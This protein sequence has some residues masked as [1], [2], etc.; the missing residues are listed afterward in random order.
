MFSFTARRVANVARNN[1][2]NK[3]PK[4]NFG[5]HEFAS[6]EERVRQCTGMYTCMYV[7]MYVCMISILHLL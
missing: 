3:M 1:A 7:C 6:T 2:C 5:G 4:R